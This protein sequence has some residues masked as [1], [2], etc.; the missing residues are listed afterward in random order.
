MARSASRP[1]GVSVLSVLLLGLRSEVELLTVATLVT[2]PVT[3]LF[4]VAVMV[5]VSVSPTARVPISH[6]GL[7]QSP[8][9]G[10]ASTRMRSF[11]RTSV[12]L[13]FKAVFGP[14]LVTTTRNSMSSPATT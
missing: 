10:T 12:T 1:T 14:R 5:R 11:D 13:T 3:S 8:V 6:T 7:F 9:V 4:T 2:V